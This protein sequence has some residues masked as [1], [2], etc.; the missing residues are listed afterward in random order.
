VRAPFSESRY[1]QR[2]LIGTSICAG[3]LATLTVAVAFGAMDSLD[4]WAREQFRPNLMWG[5]AQQRASH[6][7]TWLSPPWMLLLL[8]I[9]SAVVSVWRLS[10]WPLIQ[11]ACAVALAG[12]L[13]LSLKILVDR[14]DPKGQ[15]TSL[16]GSYPSGHSAVLLVCLVTGA[17]LISCPTRWWQRVGFVALEVVLAAA[18]LYD[19]LHW[20]SDIV[21]G[22]MAAGVAV[23]VVALVAGPDGGPSHR[24]RRH[25]HRRA[26]R[27]RS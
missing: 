2:A 3:L 4:L 21:G 9:G 27:S 20:L 26:E 6:V 13:T 17:M 14:A 25:R 19:A 18:M 24:G 23:G 15:H 10:L 8:S 22:A 11:S 7:V 5:E 12:V 1:R 16:G